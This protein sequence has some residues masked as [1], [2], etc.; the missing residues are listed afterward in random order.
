[1]TSNGI[2]P[3]C[4]PPEP[5]LVPDD[6]LPPSPPW[7]FTESDRRKAAELA[8]AALWEAGV[9]LSSPADLDEAIKWLDIAERAER[10]SRDWSKP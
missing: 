10:L 7:P 5:K 6:P 4:G 3:Y 2:G 1:M 8:S 9:A